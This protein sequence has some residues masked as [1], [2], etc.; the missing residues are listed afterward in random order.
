M[1]FPRGHRLFEQGK[2]ADCCYI[3]QSGEVKITKTIRKEPNSQF[4]KTLLTE[5]PTC[6]VEKLFGCVV[7]LGIGT[8]TEIVGNESLFTENPNWEYTVTAD[9]LTVDLISIKLSLARTFPE[10]MSEQMLE[11]HKL[12]LTHRMQLFLQNVRVMLKE[13]KSFQKP[14]FNVRQLKLVD[15]QLGKLTDNRKEVIRQAILSKG[16]SSTLHQYNNSIKQIEEITAKKK[17]LKIDLAQMVIENDLPKVQKG[18]EPTYIF[19]PSF[20][21]TTK[22]IKQLKLRRAEL[23]LFNRKKCQNDF[24][25][26]RSLNW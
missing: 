22:L 21:P 23:D 19:S 10:K 16:I 1:S 6:E 11:M 3:I 9:S 4:Y 14:P 5:L 15:F 18:A 12:K 13:D 7:S 17:S 2:P 20:K 26:L 24:V 25:F 8:E